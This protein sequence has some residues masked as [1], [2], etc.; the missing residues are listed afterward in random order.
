MLII[1]DKKIPQ[2]AREK[3]ADAGELLELET[4]SI[5]YD[6]I[7]GHP[8]VFFCRI[9]KE[10]VVAPNLPERYF[11]ILE[12]KS[13]P[14]IKGE[15][16]VGVKYPGTAGYNAVFNNNTLIH[17]FRYTDPAITRLAE[18]ADLIHVNQGY[19]RCNLVPAGPGRYIT[20]DRAVATTLRRF[21]KEVLYV[22]PEGIILPGFKNGFFGGCCGILDTKLFLIGSLEYL[23]NGNELRSFLEESGVEIIEL[24]DG[25]LFDG[26]S[27]LFTEDSH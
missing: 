7:S 23:K 4:N 5:C 13:V 15:L 1:I 25:P 8:D 20:S 6:A 16:P 27:I 18:D 2:E 22:D 12:K 14:F 3:L 26:G 17:N 10:V 11:E 19:A 24:Y 9:E 21:D